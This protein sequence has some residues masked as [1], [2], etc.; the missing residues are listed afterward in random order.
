MLSGCAF[1]TAPQPF[2]FRTGSFEVDSGGVGKV[3]G[4]GG[5]GRLEG[6]GGAKLS[7]GGGGAV[8]SGGGGGGKSASPFIASMGGG[9]GGMP[10][11]VALILVYFA[12]YI[13]RLISS[14]ITTCK[15]IDRVAISYGT[16]LYVV[17]V[18]VRGR[19]AARQG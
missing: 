12:A 9:G 6:G 15:C 4:G 16:K 8:T 7:G 3:S 1:F 2:F 11:A 10:S 18:I 19:K 5:G 14:A 13:Q 17:V